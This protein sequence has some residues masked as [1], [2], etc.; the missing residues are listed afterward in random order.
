MIHVHCVTYWLDLKCGSDV[1]RAVDEARKGA[2]RMVS[3]MSSEKNVL[4][5]QWLSITILRGEPDT[6]AF[7][8]IKFKI[9]DNS[10]SSFQALSW[11]MCTAFLKRMFISKFIKVDDSSKAASD[12]RFYCGMLPFLA[13][14]CLHTWFIFINNN[15]TTM[16]D[17]RSSSTIQIPTRLKTQKGLSVS[18]SK[19]M[20]KITSNVQEAS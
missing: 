7:L 8:F 4:Y 18:R 20:G 10:W 3:R 19:S 12:V 5:M 15:Q 11:H 13:Y 14:L 1:E 16:I 2:S 17:E 9:K 6:S